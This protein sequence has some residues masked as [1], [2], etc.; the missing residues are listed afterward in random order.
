MESKISI[1][2]YYEEIDILRAMAILMVLLYHSVIVF[3]VNLHEIPWCAG[4]HELLWVV[5]MPLFFLVSGFCFSYENGKYGS[6]FV[7][8]AKRV[9]VPHLVFGALDI[10][11]R[12]IPT[13]LVNQTEEPLPAIRDFLLFGGSD[14]FLW[15]LFVI[16]VFF[17]LF[18]FL[19][20][21]GKIGMEVTI[22]LV[23]V[24][25]FMKDK[26]P[27]VFLFSVAAEYLP[28]FFVGYLIKQ[29]GAYEMIRKNLSNIGVLVV[30]VLFTVILFLIHLEEKANGLLFLGEIPVFVMAEDRIIELVQMIT[31]LAAAV[32]VLN[33]AQLLM[34]KKV[35]SFLK[36]CSKFSLQ[37]YLLDG[38][39]LVVT[40]TV[41]VSVLG[42]TN[43]VVIIVG[44][45]VLDVA[46]TYGITR[47]II[48]PV[49]L[50]RVL[51]GL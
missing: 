42:I 4:L 25:Y 34:A 6:Y 50:F 3:P 35:F 26:I 31:A 51:C 14:W 15:T 40:R 11:M 22:L 13:G 49:R 30:S 46:I 16:F 9:L 41:L 29:S 8:K 19:F 1:K 33:L 44:N 5:E 18:H 47:F 17:P 10:A 24:I 37:M 32:V 27:G 20:Y 21:K 39:A 12:V 45:F 48:K 23:C 38:Y 2:H 36:N 28:Y 43:P 7:K